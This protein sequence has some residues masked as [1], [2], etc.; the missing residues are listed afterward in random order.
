LEVQVLQ[1]LE[2]RTR[3]M[4]ILHNLPITKAVFLQ[5]NAVLPSFAPV[6][7]LFTFVGIINRPHRGNVADKTVEQLLLLKDN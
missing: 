4:A 7:H 3:D 5:L 6:E 1:F 2:E